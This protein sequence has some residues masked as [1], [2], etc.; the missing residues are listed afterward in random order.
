M[1]PTFFETCHTKN[2]LEPSV[3]M[4]IP[5]LH[6]TIIGKFLTARLSGEILPL[7][8][9]Q[10]GKTILKGY[11]FLVHASPSLTSRDRPQKSMN[12]QENIVLFA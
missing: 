3:K 1:R 9:R 10:A 2:M 6:F 12:D 11:T 7:L 5:N 4:Q 8:Q